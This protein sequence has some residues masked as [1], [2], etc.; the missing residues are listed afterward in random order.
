M[1]KTITK[2]VLRRDVLRVLA[3]RE[4]AKVD[5]GDGG[6]GGGGEVCQIVTRVVSGCFA[7][8]D[9]DAG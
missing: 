1:K 7:G 4:L 9:S 2:L 5:G 8:P 3:G 6:G